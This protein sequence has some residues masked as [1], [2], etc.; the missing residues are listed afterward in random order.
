MFNVHKWYRARN[1]L[2]FEWPILT[3]FSISQSYSQNKHSHRCLNLLILY[4]TLVTILKSNHLRVTICTI[5][6]RQSYTE[7]RYISTDIEQDAL[8]IAII[9]VLWKLN[10]NFF[11]P[12][13][14]Y[15]ISFSGTVFSHLRLFF[16][17]RFNNNFSSSSDMAHWDVEE[18]IRRN[19]KK[20]EKNCLKN[21]L[22]MFSVCLT[23]NGIST[24]VDKR[25]VFILLFSFKYRKV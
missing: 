5:S 8:P 19:K 18:Y 12:I 2:L 16:I 15:V 13:F 25:K 3:D 22:K 4:G 9:P 1:L 20:A 10:R 7:K 17:F 24:V 6:R 11:R 14:H 23:C 21:S